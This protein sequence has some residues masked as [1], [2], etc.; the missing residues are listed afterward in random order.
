MNLPSRL[1]LGAGLIV[2]AAI[3]SSSGGHTSAWQSP[4]SSSVTLRII[5]VPPADEAV[6]IVEQLRQ[7]ADFAT[8]ASESSTEP[9]ARQGG[10]LGAL[11]PATLRPDLREALNGV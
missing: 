5:V 6:R 10:Y 8:L 3:L 4:P 9:T 2:A 7:G 11:D 1:T